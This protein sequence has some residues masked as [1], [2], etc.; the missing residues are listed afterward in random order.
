[1]NRQELYD[2]LNKV[3][4]SKYMLTTRCSVYF[5]V[6]QDGVEE[7]FY[8]FPFNR[9][10]LESSCKLI[11]E[12]ECDYKELLDYARHIEKAFKEKYVNKIVEHELTMWRNGSLY[13]IEKIQKYNF[14]ND[15]EGI[16][17]IS[18]QDCLTWL[19]E[20]DH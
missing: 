5:M 13:S 18:E 7:P 1:M 2:Y 4:V 15:I 6:R 12:C 11:K 19:I 9:H 17:P 10:Y 14:L 8:F 20:H 3:D 16:Y